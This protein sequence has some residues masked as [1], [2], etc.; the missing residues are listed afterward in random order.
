MAVYTATDFQKKQSAILKNILK[1]R[2]PVEVIVDTVKTNGSSDSVVI[3]PKD[4]YQNLIALKS[5]LV[6]Q[7][8]T[9]IQTMVLH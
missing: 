5:Q 9:D 8:T 6:Q 2:Q 4:D 1:R 7:A 3:F